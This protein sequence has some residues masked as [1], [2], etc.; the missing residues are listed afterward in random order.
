M[1]VLQGNPQSVNTIWRSRCCGRTPIVYLSDYGKKLKASYALQAQSQ[2][3]DK[4]FEDKL[5]VSVK[6]FFGDQ[7]RRD[8]DNFFKAA[9]DSLKGICYTD[10]SQI[11][12]LRAVKDVDKFFPRIEIEITS[13]TK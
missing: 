8:I 10:D 4:P 6:M 11:Y 3:K 5:S 13:L 9:L 12:E 7:K 2:W 1:I